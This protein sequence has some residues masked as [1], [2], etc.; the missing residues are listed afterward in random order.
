MVNVQ[1]EFLGNPCDK[2]LLQNLNRLLVSKPRYI[3]IYIYNTFQ[4]SAMQSTLK[5][6][7]LH[8]LNLDFFGF[9]VYI[10]I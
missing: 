3:Y 2:I 9:Y 5:I 6:T 7:K 4:R 8:A 1:M 10:Y